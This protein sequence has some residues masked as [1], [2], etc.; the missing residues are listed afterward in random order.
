MDF[1]A[2][3]RTYRVYV[4]A[5]KQFRSNPKDIEKLYVRSTT[6]EMVSMGNLVKITPTSEKRKETG[7]KPFQT[8]K[9]KTNIFQQK[10]AVASD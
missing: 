3:G 8:I 5:D 7:E 10:K 1:N 4:Q 2:F 6:G 9:L